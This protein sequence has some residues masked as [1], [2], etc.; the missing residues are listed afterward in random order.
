MKKSL[1]VLRSEFSQTVRQSKMLLLLFFLVMLYETTLS[2]MRGIYK[3]TLMP[4]QFSEPIILLFS[5]GT[6][7]VLM[8]CIYIVLLSGFPYCR[9]HYF[10]MI[11]TEKRQWLAGELLFIVLSALA[12]IFVIFGGS[13]IFL[14]DSVEIK[15]GWSDYMIIMRENFPEI[16]DKNLSLFLSS[17]TVAHGTPFEVFFYTFGMGWAYLVIMGLGMLLGA[18]LG[19]RLIG[20]TACVGVTLT[21]GSTLLFGTNFKWVF[22]LAHIDFGEHFNSLFSKINFPVWGS[23]IYFAIIIVVLVI[24][25]AIS[26]R[27]MKVG[28]DL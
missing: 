26:L 4:P 25:C 11:R 2:P 24:L 23:L 12:E 14:A 13:L 27:K 3:E 17:S 6:N 8:P 28:D 9:T 18:I 5:K 15:S 1:F 16:Y 22:P 20:I 21:G 7:I 19:K 10:Q